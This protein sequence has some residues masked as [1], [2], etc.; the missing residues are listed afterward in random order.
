MISAF[1]SIECTKAIK[2]NNRSTI[3]SQPKAAQILTLLQMCWRVHWLFTERKTK[4]NLCAQDI[5]GIKR[6]IKYRFLIL[7][8]YWSSKFWDCDNYILA[9]HGNIYAC[10]H[11]STG[12]FNHT[13]K[14]S[15]PTVIPPR[16][17]LCKHM[18]FWPISTRCHYLMSAYITSCLLVL[19]NKRPK[20]TW[21]GHN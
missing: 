20:W 14:S 4:C 6:G 11:V 17:L 12:I 13:V 15:Y 5:C 18:S 1:F 19:V 9:N 2:K 3:R 21:K 7:V 10:Q 16:I 8:F